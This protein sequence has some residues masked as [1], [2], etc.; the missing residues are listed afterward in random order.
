MFEKI[1][2]TVIE[3]SLGTS[4]VIFLFLLPNRCWTNVIPPSGDIGSGSF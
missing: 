3:I 2:H 1:F 4:V